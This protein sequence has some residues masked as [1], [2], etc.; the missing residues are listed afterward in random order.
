M[1][2]AERARDGCETS[3]CTPATSAS[4]ARIIFTHGTDGGAV[5]TGDLAADRVVGLDGGRAL[6]DRG[7]ARRGSAAAPRRSPR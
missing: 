1:P 3:S 2:L 6:V 4:T 5:L 7:D